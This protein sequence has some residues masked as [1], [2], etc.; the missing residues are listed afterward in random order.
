MTT[1]GRRR[2]QIRRACRA[3]ASRPS[4]SS[5]TREQRSASSRYGVA[6]RIVMPCARNSESSFQN[7]RRDTGS[8][9]V[10]GSSSRMILGSCT[11]VQASASFCFIPPDSC[12]ASASRNGASCVSS[13]R[14]SP[15]IADGRIAHAEAVNLGEE[16]DVFVDGEIAVQAEPLRQVAE[17]LRHLAGAASPDRGR[18]RARFRRPAS[19]ARTSA[20]SPWSCR[21]R[22]ARSGR[23]SRPRSTDIDRSRRATTSPYRFADGIELQCR[24]LS[25]SPELS[26]VTAAVSPP[27]PASPA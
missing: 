18:A 11:S 14:R 5:A 6:I 10:V 19:A 1:P 27:R 24:H 25:V 2:A 26:A 15:A 3:R 13:S 21:R 23:T 8:T 16:R 12:S 20:E 7:S 9:P 4:C 22:P 17:R